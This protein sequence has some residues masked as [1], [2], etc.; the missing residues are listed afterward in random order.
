MLIGIDGNEA[1]VKNRV[2]VGEFAYGVI[3]GLYGLDKRNQYRIYLKEPPLPDLPPERENWQYR[4][5]GPKFAWTQWR[6]P[7]KLRHERPRLSVFFSPN[8]YAPRF[9]PAP[10]VISIMDLW[11]HYHSEQFRSKDVYQLKNWEA[12][13]VKQA[14]KIIAISEFTKSEII[15]FYRVP[16]EKVVVAYPGIDTRHETR[17]MRHEIKKKYG[18][19]DE[20]ILYLGTLQ[21]KKNLGRLI[22]AFNILYTTYH[23]PHT[24]L[25]VAGKKGWLYE[26]IFE[27]VKKVKMEKEVIFTDF[28]PEED[29]SG[30]IIGASCFVLPSLYE[31]FG[32]PVLEA[33]AIGVPVAISKAASLPEVGRE[34][35]FYFD[36]EKP[37]SIA[38]T[39]QKVLKLSSSK[40][41][42]VIEEGKKQAG[43][44]TWEKC[45]RKILEVLE[46][47]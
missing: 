19:R 20:Y 24:Q 45:A 30:L 29:K 26:E 42:K 15:K 21:P 47:V 36:P 8:H 22:E 38:E 6:L 46:N 12:Y 7:L 9:C 25:V 28:I 32:I 3:K 43:K 18:I 2:G 4:V 41:K 14:R 27:R 39:I 37:E 16:E 10:S 40:R 34:A 1:N 35:A 44:F 5:F 11:H 13:S 23:I 33:M 31:G 17:D